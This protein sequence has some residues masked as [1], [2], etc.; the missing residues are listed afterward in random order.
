MVC[1]HI[2]SHRYLFAHSGLWLGLPDLFRR[3]DRQSDPYPRVARTSVREL[4]FTDSTLCHIIVPHTFRGGRLLWVGR[5]VRSSVSRL[6]P[7]T[8]TVSRRAGP[9]TKMLDRIQK[10]SYQSKK[11][12]PSTKQAHSHMIEIHECTDTC[13]EPPHHSHHEYGSPAKNANEKTTK[14]TM[15]RIKRCFEG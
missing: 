15:R 8:F 9:A 14:W 1:S 13:T 7:G 6:R 5:F 11:D 4:F 10:Y 2:T 12:V 3:R